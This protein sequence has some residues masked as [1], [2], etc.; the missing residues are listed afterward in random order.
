MNTW[1]LWLP[2]RSPPL[3]LNQRMHYMAEKRV[4]D[5]LKKTAWT[6]AK[7][8]K[9]PRLRA[10]T[11]ELR[12]LKPDNRRAD[13]DNMAP[14]LKP[15]LDGLVAAGVLADDNSD[16]VLR[17]SSKILL[18]R[19]RDLPGAHLILAIRDMSTLAVHDD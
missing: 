5:D 15:L 3:S 10:I 17:T 18:R 8:H 2:Y 1:S 4:K 13:P 19:D 11:A 16:H 7:H 14:T 12:W 9:L 6:L